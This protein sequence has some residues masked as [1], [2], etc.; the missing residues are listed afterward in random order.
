ML[1]LHLIETRDDEVE[2]ALTR[3]QLS[4]VT[5]RRLWCRSDVSQAL[6]AE[7]NEWLTR[8]GWSLFLSDGAYGAVRTGIVARWP[9]VTTKSIVETLSDVTLGKCNFEAFE[10]LLAEYM[11]S[12]SDDEAVADDLK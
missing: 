9:R 2:K 7:V 1:F 10:P 8:A 3:V 6:I 11:T 12:E 4:V 5:L